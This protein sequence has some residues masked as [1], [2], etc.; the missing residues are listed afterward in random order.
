MEPSNFRVD[1]KVAIVTGAGRGMG[2]TFA[3]ALALAGA[4]VVVTELPDREADAHETAQKVIAAGR[5]AMVAPL[6]V[7][8]QASIH[9][10][11]D[12]VLD[13]WGP[14]RHSREQCRHEHPAVRHRCD[15]GCLG[16]GHRHRPE[17]RLL[18]RS[19][20][21]PSHGRARTRAARSS[22]SPPSSDSWASHNVSPTARRRPAW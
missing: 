5:R 21:R 22:T 15:G 14:H 10:V 4:D 9:A 19:G 17:R 3:E 8:E 2:G 12:R 7:T 11:V 16:Q 20:G 6:D 13:E 1:S 18:L